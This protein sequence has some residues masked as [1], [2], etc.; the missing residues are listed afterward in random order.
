MAD[1][2]ERTA[3]EKQ[4][5]QR[6][7][8]LILWQEEVT[9]F[10]FVQN[11]RLQEIA[12]LVKRKRKIQIRLRVLQKYQESKIS[13]HSLNRVKFRETPSPLHLIQGEK[14]AQTT[15]W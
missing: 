13:R 2:Q 3:I 11:Y 9:W 5:P 6:Q 14:S 12:I 15:V 4:K 10:Y 7:Q 1:S 8:L